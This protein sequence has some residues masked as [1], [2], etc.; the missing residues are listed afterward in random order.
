MMSDFGGLNTP[1]CS[2]CGRTDSLRFF[3]WTRSKV[4]PLSSDP[5]DVLRTSRSP[6]A[7]IF[8][9]TADSSSTSVNVADTWRP[10]PGWVSR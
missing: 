10:P 5:R 8:I 7:V 9:C 3:S 1:A 2:V 6:A 4:Q